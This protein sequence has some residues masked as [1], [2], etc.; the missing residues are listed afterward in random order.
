MGGDE[1]VQIV[2]VDERH[3]TFCEPHYV[4]PL[5]LVTIVAGVDGGADVDRVPSPGSVEEVVGQVGLILNPP[6]PNRSRDGGKQT[7]ECVSDRVPYTG[8]AKLIIITII[9]LNNSSIISLG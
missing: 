3:Y 8:F 7:H 4:E 9:I 6:S 5:K 2:L 1:W